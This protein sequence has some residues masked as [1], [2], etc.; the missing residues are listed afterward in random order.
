MATS[1]FLIG[2][3]G[4]DTL[5]HAIVIEPVQIGGGA[6]SDVITGGSNNDH[7]YGNTPDAIAGAADGN[8]RIFG[9]AGHDYIQGN[10]G[11]DD[12]FGGDGNDRIYGGAGEDDLHG[13]DGNDHLQGNRGDDDLE[14]GAGDDTL[15]GGADNDELEG[16][17]G[18]DQL[19]GDN[20]N[21]ELQGG[22]GIDVL[23]GGAGRDTFEFD[24]N[25][26]LIGSGS[27]L[28]AVDTITDFTEGQ[29]EIDLDFDVAQVLTAVG[30]SFA[31]LAA[32]QS[33]ATQLLTGD[34]GTREVAALGV[35]ADTFLFFTG[36]GGDAVDSVVRLANVQP[37]TITTADFD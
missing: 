32:A 27:S 17:S 12:L 25:D 31:D 35:G 23:T 33:Y 15:R 22:L 3:D 4:N 20:G 1:N 36:W 30:Q 7:L 8:D 13:G 29:D 28:S 5:D 19:L 34:A 18:N 37:D 9:G 14:G 6:G 21:D 11:D 16:G 24:Q 10:A 26:A 2:S